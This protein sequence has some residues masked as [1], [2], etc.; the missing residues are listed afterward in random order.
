MTFQKIAGVVLVVMLVAFGGYMAMGPNGEPDTNTV[1]TRTAATEPAAGDEAA[2]PVETGETTTEDAEEA[3][4][5]AAAEDE[6]PAVEDGEVNVE[7]A[8]QERVL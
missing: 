2:A 3:A 6:A 4:S 5:E 1:I 8:M 7:K